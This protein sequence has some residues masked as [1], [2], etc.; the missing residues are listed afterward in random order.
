VTVAK[1]EEE[2]VEATT[3][4]PV[5]RLR[6]ERAPLE[7]EDLQIG[8]NLLITVILTE[9]SEAELSM[10]FGVGFGQGRLF[11]SWISLPIPSSHPP[12]FSYLILPTSTLNR[13]S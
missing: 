13:S 9:N 6:Q 4:L 3:E 12:S 11:F 5:E 1:E 2:E 8:T 7:A 10:R